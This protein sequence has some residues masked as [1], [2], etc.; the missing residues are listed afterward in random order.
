MSTMALIERGQ[1][2]AK[3]LT[4]GEYRDE[5]WHRIQLLWEKI[6][7]EILKE[8]EQQGD[9]GYQAGTEAYFNYLEK[10]GYGFI[11]GLESFVESLA[12]RYKNGEI[13]AATHN[14]YLS[15]VKH[16][17]RK[18][19]P[20]LPIEQKAYLEEWLSE[21][22]KKR[23]KEKSKTV[24]ESK[25]L[26][27]EEIQELIRYL[28]STREGSKSKRPEHWG[29]NVALMTEFMANSGARVSEM[30]GIRLTDIKLNRDITI[31]L[32]GKGRREREIPFSDRAL[33]DHI[34][35][36]FRGKTYLFEHN[37]K[38]FTRQ[39]VITMLKKAGRDLWGKE[40][41]P[42]TLRHSFATRAIQKGVDVKALSEHLGHSSTSITLDMYVHTKMSKKQLKGLWE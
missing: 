24:P 30:L 7:A 11:Q 27:R 25:I 28:N 10:E 36:H 20:H 14:Q 42:H 19:K 39:Y 41:S 17:I 29:K 5:Q 40:I 21:L 33:L 35:D 38:R 26:T 12:E 3:E 2:M 22:D 6:K 9:G 34:K 15:T 18:I 4:N 32:R 1:L 23:V 37:G 13:H 16:H 8:I 31:T